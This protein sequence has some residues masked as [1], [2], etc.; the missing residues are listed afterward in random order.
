MLINGKRALAYTVHITDVKPIEG[1]DNIELAQINGWT[2][3]ARKQEFQPGDL[4]VFFEIDSKL[5]AESWSEFLA[6]REYK[7]KTMKLNKFCVISQGLALPF[8]NFPENIRKRLPKESEQDVTE[9]LGVT[10]IVDEDNKRKATRPNFENRVS[11]IKG[12][13]KKFFSNPI[14]K[15][16]MRF[17]WFRKLMVF[18]FP[19]PNRNAKAFPKKFPFIKPSDEDRIQNLPNLLGYERPLVVTEKLDGTSTTFILERKKRGKYEFYVCSRNVRQLT[20]EQSC[21]HDKNVYWDMAK[22]YN[23]EQHLKEYLEDYPELDYVCIQGETVGSVQGNP[24]RLTED[25]FYCFNFIDSVMGRHPSTF[26]KFII[27]EWGM[28]W[29]PIL[30]TE[31]KMPN[32]MEEILEYA[33]AKSAVNPQVLR[34]GVVIRDPVN[35]LSFK[36]VSNE[37][38]LKHRI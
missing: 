25:D 38:L 6:P 21:Y 34:E 33:T 16:L 9:F 31:F 27:Q 15:Y 10:Y 28:K 19:K 23:V 18:V 36:A 17:K 35:D 13:H 3:I 5:P 12:K 8:S 37:Y 7:V 26:G 14:I 2:C 24:L 22:K 32:T 30:D 29:V 11:N 20:P 1:A 4:A